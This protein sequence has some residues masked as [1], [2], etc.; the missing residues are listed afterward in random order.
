MRSF[1]SSAIAILITALAISSPRAQE[2]KKPAS[3]GPPEFKAL[4]YRPIGPAA[5]GRVSRV[6]GVPGDPS[7]AYAATASATLAEAA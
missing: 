2:D 6:A 4:K 7:T 1:K 3:G 5:G